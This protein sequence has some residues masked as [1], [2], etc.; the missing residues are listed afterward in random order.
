MPEIISHLVYRKT[1]KSPK[2]ADGM[3]NGVD[4]DQTAPPIWV[5]TICSDLSGIFSVQ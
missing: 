5:C 3:G 4:P 1:P 2:D